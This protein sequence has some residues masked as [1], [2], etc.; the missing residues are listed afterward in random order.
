MLREA[1]L[2]EISDG[3]I[4]E[5]NDMVKAD[6]GN[7][8][9]CHKCCC[10]MG[11]SIVLDPYDVIRILN[12]LNQSF[13]QLLDNGFVELNMVDGMILPNLRMGEQDTCQFL[14]E[15]GKC[16]IHEARPGICRLFPLGRVYMG[17][18]F[19]YFLQ[20]GEC[21]KDNLAKVKVRKWISQNNIR[22]YEAFINKWHAF[23]RYI[24]D[25]MYE[26]RNKA[27]GDKLSEIAMFVLNEFYVKCV[28]DMLTDN[29][30][31]EKALLLL[32][33]E[34]INWACEQIEL[35]IK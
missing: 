13:Q 15:E 27:A 14:N 17:D 33:T 23:I 2:E 22:E 34:K 9:G 19:K 26:L 16:S 4:Y 3:R 7:C 8:E 24:G 18:D 6:T 32:L 5:L 10:G 30:A 31:Y 20:K 21:I 29:E 12:S 25:K 35:I 28:A 1:T 11:S